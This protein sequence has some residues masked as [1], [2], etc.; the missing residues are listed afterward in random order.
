MAIDKKINIPWTITGGISTET[1][2]GVNTLSGWTNKLTEFKFTVNPHS[3][4]YFTPPWI[5]NEDLVWDLGDGTTFKGTSAVHV[6]KYP[7]SYKVSLVAYSSAGQEYYSTETKELSVTNFFADSLQLDTQDVI[8]ILNIP[9]GSVV[10]PVKLIRQ[11]SWQPHSALSGDNYTI[12]LYSSGSN[13]RKLDIRRYNQYKWAHLDHTWAF[14]ESITAN[15]GTVSYDPINSINTTGDEEIYFIKGV[16]HDSQTFDR[17][18]KSFLETASGVSAVF[19]G[20]SGAAE[21]YY[22]D[23]IPK[24]TEDPVFIYGHIDTTKFPHYGQLQDGKL[25]SFSPLK[26]FEH[27]GITIPVRVKYN[28]A[29]GIKF[30]SSGVSTMDLSKIKYQSTEV[31]FFISLSGQYSN[32]ARH[33]PPLRVLPASASSTATSDTYIV[34][35]STVSG[36][37][38]N[39]TGTSL[40]STHY[41]KDVDTQLPESL[42]GMFRGHFV[43]VHH[44]DNVALKGTVVVT[45]PPNFSKDVYF[46]F[47]TNNDHGLEKRIFFKQNYSVNPVVGTVH[48]WKDIS[49]VSYQYDPITPAGILS[50]KTIPIS[51][52]PKNDNLNNNDVLA[53]IGNTLYSTL[54]TLNAY[55]QTVSSFDIN[56]IYVTPV[57]EIKNITE[58]YYVGSSNAAPSATSISIDN[59]RSVYIA[60]PEISVVEHT[61]D[62][63]AIDIY[64]HI[65]ENV[66]YNSVITGD[67]PLSVTKGIDIVPVGGGR[68]NTHNPSIVESGKHNNVWIAYTNPVSSAIRQYENSQTIK[69]EYQFDQP[70]STTDMVVDNTGNLWATVENKFRHLYGYTYEGSVNDYQ[71][72]L[73][74]I[75]VSC[76]GTKSDNQFNYVLTTASFTISAD[77]IFETTG[78]T[79]GTAN[80]KYFNGTFLVDSVSANPTK[81]SI[82]VTPY[83]GRYNQAADNTGTVTVSGFKRPSDRVYKFDALGTKVVS[84]SGFLNPTNV[85]VDSNQRPWISHNSDTLTQLTTAGTKL[86]DIVVQSSSFVTNY[87][88][89]GSDLTKAIA[90]DGSTQCPLSG[91]PHHIGGISFNTFDNLLVLNSFE[92][93]LFY[94]PLNS[95]SL[96][97]VYILGDGMSPVSADHGFTYG[98]VNGT[99][100]WTGFRWLNK[101]NNT[102]GTRTLTGQSTFSVFSSA[103][104]NKLL[105]VNENY[106]PQ[107]NLKQHR[108][109]PNLLDYD[110]LFDDFLGTIVGNLSSDPTDIGRVVYEKIANFVDNTSDPD[111]CNINALYSLC[112][113]YD[114]DINNYNFT[115]PGRLKRIMDILSISRNRLWGHREKFDRDLDILRPGAILHPDNLGLDIDMTTYVVSA[116]QPIVA[117]HLFNSEIVKIDTGMVAPFSVT[118]WGSNTSPHYMSKYDTVSAYPLSAYT[119]YWGW[120]LM[121]DISGTDVSQHIKFYEY[122]RAYSNTQLEGIVDWSNIQTT[123]NESTSSIVDWTKD[124]GLV[125]QLIDYELRKGLNLFSKQLSAYTTGIL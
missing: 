104:K 12:N 31:P 114:I 38:T 74:A 107:D 62:N 51:I 72:S 103:G 17:V 54:C 55:N 23:D 84:V 92:N 80:S 27:Y 50:N 83:I 73:S 25:E 75:D 81:T 112:E 97:G 40:L 105:K 48:T 37:N 46:G 120:G 94:I 7:G 36:S 44:S 63:N 9:A 109:V 106:D 19:V 45:D 29:V 82:T 2:G 52:V 87:V 85:I 39:F 64:S 100:D 99:G 76:V 121:H 69:S 16:R 8:N 14:Y 4:H 5:S 108:F 86:Q 30:T 71:R 43:P 116:D 6:Y 11:N 101:Y 119:P 117:K 89:A 77:E 122:T 18:T 58:S 22:V 88:S 67:S 95:P 90:T 1:N 53:Y 56:N 115:Y 91:Q 13:S 42:S 125:D 70:L 78:F 59:D 110:V 93:K 96:S 65:S 34:N 10:N 68:H 79:G 60:L 24:L 47:V 124:Y 118:G 57:S 41:F 35:L 33:Y 21:F 61:F 20:T 26:Y 102:T 123:L 113:M 66:T 28:P 111:T 49:I 15:D 3:V 98:K 32:T